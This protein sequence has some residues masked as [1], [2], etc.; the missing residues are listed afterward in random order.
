MSGKKGPKSIIIV[1]ICVIILESRVQLWSNDA[2]NLSEWTSNTDAEP[3]LI[4]SNICPAS[5][6]IYCIEIFD[7]DDRENKCDI[8]IGT[9]TT[10]NYKSVE[11][12]FWAAADG[13]IA[14]CRAY[15]RIGRNGVWVVLWNGVGLFT[16]AKVA[17]SL[18]NDADNID[19]I[20]YLKFE[21]TDHN[22]RCYIDNI[23]LYGTIVGNPVPTIS[24]T[25]KS[26][27]ASPTI[28]SE[29]L[30]PTIM[31]SLNPTQMKILETNVHNEENAND[32]D[33]A[34]SV[35]IKYFDNYI[36]LDLV[37][38]VCILVG[39][40]CCMFGIC[41][42]LLTYL[43]VKTQH[44][45]KTTN[46]LTN[47]NTNAN[48]NRTSNINISNIVQSSNDIVIPIS[49][50][51]YISVISSSV[52]KIDIKLP[53]TIPSVTSGDNPEYGIDNE[54]SIVDKQLNG[55]T[56]S[57]PQ[58]IIKDDGEISVAEPKPRQS[59]V[60][61]LYIQSDITVQSRHGNV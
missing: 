28:K 48:D 17:R 32:N 44:V 21:N 14:T 38:F 8:Q 27:T 22:I 1:Y 7:R 5:N 57:Y 39:V 37:L 11:I 46:M 16:N 49:N 26:E 43:V 58:H 54:G 9:V 33:D 19:E 18:G 13:N 23:R 41:M 24:P 34:T 45:N 29:I 4:A 47:T 30:S 42:V 40:C 51:K 60:S 2:D 53:S 25:I 50:P 55:D 56:V 61:E 6:D 20:I 15:R 3:H 10:L 52:N 59:N 35:V 31:P 12:E 36:S